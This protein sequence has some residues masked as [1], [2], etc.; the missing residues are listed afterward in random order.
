MRMRCIVRGFLSLVVGTSVLMVASSSPLAARSGEPGTS[1][2][3][4]AACVQGSN[5]G[6]GAGVEGDTTSASTSAFHAGVI[7][8]DNAGTSQ[9]LPRNNVGTYGISDFGAGLAGQTTRGFGVFATNA[10]FLI[11]SEGRL[12]RDASEGFLCVGAFKARPCAVVGADDEAGRERATAGLFD[13]TNGLGIVGITKHTGPNVNFGAP[14]V[15]GDDLSFQ[16][17]TQNRGIEGDSLGGFG[18]LGFTFN[19]SNTTGVSRAGVI[20]VDDSFDSGTMNVGVEAFSRGI[21]ML[22]FTTAPERP[23]GSA[24]L[25][26]L[27]AIC[28]GGGPAII[29]NDGTS[30]PGGDVAS[31]DCAGNLVLAGALVQSGSPLIQTGTSAGRQ[32]VSF[33]GRTTR[34]TIEDDGEAQLVNGSAQVGIDA[35]FAATIDHRVPYLVFI[36]PDGPNAGLYV[37][38][39]TPAGFVV[40]ENAGGHSTLVFDYRIVASPADTVPQRLP[41]LAESLRGLRSP[42]M[43]RVPALGAP[44][45]VSKP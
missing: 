29:A 39:K 28:G 6:S 23:R 17:G 42:S 26:A 18:V 7:G 24:Q 4:S 16:S 15:F 12:R 25:P 2:D 11:P 31:L 14:G 45:P 27:M 5:A 35:Q 36:T 40:R 44:Q 30:S 20:G 8:R 1:C 43:H 9:L 34:P 13:S 19:Q 21:G 37:A 3:S 41:N 32:V 33:A 22:A 38:G 10:D